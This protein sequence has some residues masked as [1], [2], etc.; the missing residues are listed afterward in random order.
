MAKYRLSIRAD[1]DLCDIAEY[2]LEKWG[3]VQ[4]DRYL[5]QLQA[6]CERLAYTPQLDRAFGEIRPGMMR[7]N[8]GEHMILYR[9]EPDGIRV[10]RV[11]HQRMLPERHLGDDE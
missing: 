5:N 1:N 10:V 9:R 2:T 11:L 7:R 4:T 6:C 8:E 3:E